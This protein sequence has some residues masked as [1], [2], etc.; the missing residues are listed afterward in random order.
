[1]KNG[2]TAGQE[3]Q[4]VRYATMARWKKVVLGIMFVGVPYLWAKVRRSCTVF[5][6]SCF[7]VDEIGE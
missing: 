2:V 5:S 6:I 1:M 3:L 7:E 4:N